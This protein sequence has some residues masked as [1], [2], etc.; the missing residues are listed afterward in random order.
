MKYANIA[1]ITLGILAGC[2]NKENTTT[3]FVTNA[4]DLRINDDQKTEN[5]RILDY[6]NNYNKAS[7]KQNSIKKVLWNK[8][9]EFFNN[10]DFNVFSALI[11][12]ES[13][14]D[15]LAQSQTNAIWFA[16][17]KNDA[18]HD[19]NVFLIKN[20]ISPALYSPLKNP[21]DNI[22]YGKIYYLLV[23]NEIYQ[24][25]TANHLFS[26][27]H[28]VD[29][30][31]IWAYNLWKTK[32]KW[33]II[34]SKAKSRTDFA[35]RLKRKANIKIKTKEVEDAI[36]EVK[37]ISHLWT[38]DESMKYATD[39]TVV[40]RNKKQDLILR[41]DKLHET[42]RYGDL[43]QW[44]SKKLAEK[45]KTSPY[46][47]KS[48][49][50]YSDFKEELVDKLEEPWIIQQW[51]SR[52]IQNLMQEDY[53]S[54]NR[55]KKVALTQNIL[56]L[57]DI[58][59]KQLRGV[60][61]ETYKFDDEKKIY[62][63]SV[64]NKLTNDQKFLKKIDIIKLLDMDKKEQDNEMSWEPMS[65]EEKVR[66][67]RWFLLNSV[68][69]YNEQ[70]RYS[71]NERAA[72]DLFVP[73]DKAYYQYYMKVMAQSVK[74]KEDK[75]GQDNIDGFSGVGKLKNIGNVYA[76]KSLD[77]KWTEVVKKCGKPHL[78]FLQYSPDNHAVN[79]FRR[80]V[81]ITPTYVVLHQTRH[82]SSN[83]SLNARKSTGAHFVILK[84]WT[85]DCLD[86]NI[87]DWSKKVCRINH[88]GAAGANKWALWD[89]KAN[90]TNLSIGIEI[91]QN[92]SA[93][94]T[95]AQLEAIKNL[96]NY[97]SY[98]Y[99]IPKSHFVSHYQIALS[100]KMQNRGRKSDGFFYREKI[101]WPNNN[102]LLDKD[103]VSG[104]INPNM[105]S[106]IKV[107]QNL[108][109]TKKEIIGMLQGISSSILI[110]EAKNNYKL[111]WNDKKSRDT[112]EE[113][114]R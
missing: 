75:K 76:D 30:F 94:E 40:I 15:K 23:R 73:T 91:E 10:M 12:K 45:V 66:M 70:V 36:Y 42:L 114:L 82:W 90:I 22:L 65:P 17:L 4:I 92:W 105:R 58:E 72:E 110:N 77:K 9:E 83:Y 74:P 11:I 71:W 47:F 79:Q 51:S 6:I 2:A 89:W 37:Y 33:L 98:Y 107:L 86:K 25:L 26:S 49:K 63:W 113:L 21:E 56:E 28:E 54:V 68:L 69:F 1:A 78:N 41:K 14:L 48:G 50:S 16:Q 18:I 109:Y 13:K 99:N 101:W 8:W 24:F 95:A 102:K 55:Q 60:K 46:V 64:I 96:I 34:E 61:Y 31:T 19:V 85:I 20:W 108:W 27:E 81:L 7:V 80:N 44:I 52:Y 93:K 53:Q 88:A 87:F 100:G 103:V 67:I 104:K 32:L 38:L 5:Q 39:K 35:E 97:L 111:W 43:I 62:S 59:D 84:N 29:L 106:S 3:S 57:F 112:A